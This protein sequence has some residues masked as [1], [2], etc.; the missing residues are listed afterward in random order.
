MN[1]LPLGRLLGSLFIL[2][3]V[4]SS[5]S[6]QLTVEQAVISTIR[7]MEA[8]VEDGERRAF[9]NLVAEDFDGQDGQFNHQ[10]LNAFMI[11]QFRQHERAHAQ[12][13]PITVTAE[14]TGNE[15][16]GSKEGGNEEARA[17]VAKFRALIIGGPGWIPERGR[18]LEFNT[19]WREIEGEWLLVSAQ[20]EDVILEQP[21]D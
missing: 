11:V 19:R 15:E 4:S 8:R 6:E 13:F 20:W 16:I 2:L 12:L 21:F 14:D 5:C 18:L 9:M 1:G 3:A 17:A 10:R 7:E